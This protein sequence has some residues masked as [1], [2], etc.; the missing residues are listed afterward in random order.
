MTSETP[1]LH[2]SKNQNTS[3][4]KQDIEKLKTPLR[5]DWKRCSDALE[6][7]ST[8]FR[9]RPTSTIAKFLPR[10]CLCKIQRVVYEYFIELSFSLPEQKIPS[11]VTSKNEFWLQD[12][13]ERI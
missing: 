13:S 1:N 6:I 8:I 11:P 4:T 7:G 3:K 2:F 12:E 5:F 10:N 9:R